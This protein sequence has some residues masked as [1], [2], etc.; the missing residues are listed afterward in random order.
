VPGPRR[1]ERNWRRSLTT[2]HA[3]ATEIRVSSHAPAQP[4]DAERDTRLERLLPELL[5]RLL[6]AGYDR[7]TEGPEALRNFLGDLKLPKEA[8]AALAS[9]LEE[10][11]GGLYRAVVAEVR[12]FLLRTSVAD[13]LHRALTGLALE[14][15]TEIRFVPRQSSRSRPPSHAAA[16][17]V[18]PDSGGSAPP[19]SVPTG[20]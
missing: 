17:S 2:Q 6:E 9:Q 14:I 20:A 18:R 19:T 10:G 11:R 7:I 13:E 5:R 4:E 12:D 8:I 3:Q 15:K 1:N 16:G